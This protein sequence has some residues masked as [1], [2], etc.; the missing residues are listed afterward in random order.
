MVLELYPRMHRR[1]T[2]LAILGPVLDGYGTWLLEQGYS[3]ERIRKHFCAA[4]R[5]VHRL[6][7]RDVETLASLTRARLRACAPADSQEDPN[8][9]VLVRQLEQYCE[10]ELVLYPPP[11]LTRIERRVV[12]YRT[13]L[14]EVRGFAPATVAHHGR[15][16]SEFLVHIG[17]ETRPTRLAALER[18]DLDAFLCAVSP[19]QSRASLQHVVGHLRAFLRSLAADGEI[20]T[21][22]DTQIDTPRVYRGE[23]PSLSSRVR[24]QLT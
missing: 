8:L 2:S 9:A 18:Q 21:G 20:P 22:L 24:S 3:A 23:K 14:E 1:Y 11:A 17:Y 16:V 19:R 12:A 13:Y 15:T 7:Q 5:L 4:R 10:S 6:Q